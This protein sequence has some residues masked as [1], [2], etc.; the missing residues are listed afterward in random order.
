MKYLFLS[1]L[2]TV[3]FLSQTSFGQPPR[4]SFDEEFQ[5]RLEDYKGF[6]QPEVYQ[7]LKKV[8]LK[9]KKPSNEF[10]PGFSQELKSYYKQLDDTADQ[11]ICK[12]TRSPVLDVESPRDFLN[13]LDKA[14]FKNAV[15]TPCNPKGKEEVP[16][17]ELNKIFE[18]LKKNP[19]LNNGHPNGECF[20]RA[21]LI[22]QKLDQLGYKSK[23][24]MTNGWVVAAY[25]TKKGFKA[26]GYDVHINNLVKVKTPEGVKEYI[27]DPMYF[28]RP[29]P[30]ETYKS[31]V[32]IQDVKNQY[33]ELS[34]SY[35]EAPTKS[36]KKS[37]SCEYNQYLLEKAK[38]ASSNP[39]NSFYYNN[40]RPAFKTREAAV[41]EQ[42]KKF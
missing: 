28:D 38:A 21:Y 8:K 17:N 13:A 4:L 40:D 31:L 32:S 27:V 20:N 34:Q 12:N 25:Q 10:S 23:Q 16:L 19:M 1:S 35:F 14:L 33:T 39:P 3:M 5:Q 42:K 41:L 2:F 9:K 36:S 29:V 24:L 37:D 22:S 11:I 30:L 26:E 18:E 6:V 7:T 15:R